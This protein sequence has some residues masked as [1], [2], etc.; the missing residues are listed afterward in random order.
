M[1][2]QCPCLIPHETPYRRSWFHGHWVGSA[3]TLTTGKLSLLNPSHRGDVDVSISIPELP[4]VKSLL[5]QMK[6][7]CLLST[8]AN[9]LEQTCCRKGLARKLAKQCLWET[10][11]RGAVWARVTRPVLAYR[12][13]TRSGYHSWPSIVAGLQN[14]DML[15]MLGD[16]IIHI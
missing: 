1:Q 10:L 16:S 8:C 7:G 13:T 4:F 2:S 6:S 12:C 15:N 9:V 14:I 5:N 3:S 11:M